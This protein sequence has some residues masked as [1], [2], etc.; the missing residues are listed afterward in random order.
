[1]KCRKCGAELLD[2]DTFCVNCGQKVE[3]IMQCPNCGEALREG[4]KFCHKCGTMISSE[5]E[6]EEI[7]LVQQKTVDIPFDEI[8]QGILLQ[9]EQAII[10]RPRTEEVRHRPRSEE[11]VYVEKPVK[12]EARRSYPAPRYEEDYEEEEDE[13]EDDSDSG[14]KIATIILGIVVIAAALAVGFIL[15]SRNSP[16]RY[17]RTDEERQEQEE[18][19]NSEEGGG[20]DEPAAE[21]RLQILSNVNVRNK[22]DKDNSEVLMVAKEGETYEYYEL[23][24]DAW[25]H[26]RLEDGSEGYVYKDYV[27]DLK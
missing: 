7:P 18:D 20:E 12:R 27:E 16:S 4:E 5:P 17:D 21:G 10:K 11:T 2:T 6:D 9:A 26:I 14:M 19:G 13:E 25:Y 23:V 8:E 3:R 1:M 24:N 22:P 15:W